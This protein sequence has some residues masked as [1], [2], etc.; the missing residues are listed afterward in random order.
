MVI[1]LK[2][3]IAV[4]GWLYAM[5][6]VWGSSQAAVVLNQIGDVNAYAFEAA[7]GPSPSQI[8]TDFSGYDTMVLEDFTVLSSE[9]QLTQ[10]SALF[11][12]Q[13]GFVAFQG[14][15]GYSLNV[16]SS[17]ALA[18]TSL[19]GDVAS[20]MVNAGTGA[21]VHEVVGGGGE[22]GLVSLAVNVPLPSAGT[23]WI[24]ISPVSAHSVTGQFLLQNSGATGAVTPGNA[25]AKL[26]NP[27]GQ[28]GL[29]TLSSTN[30]DYAYAVTAVPEPHVAALPVLAGLGWLLRR[31]R[32][33]PPGRKS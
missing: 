23:Y 22:Y 8:F 29:G 11:R 26:A 1:K 30:L 2:K 10:V 21:S 14:V 7:P 33:R 20:L 4:H 6:A 12:A 18:A 28:L 31:R 27:G 24:G 15:Q 13:G 17:S 9:L 32:I 16:F 25:N 19:T 3:R 5:C